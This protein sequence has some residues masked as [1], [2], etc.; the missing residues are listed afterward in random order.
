M[1]HSALRRWLN[2]GD[3][4]LGPWQMGR[5]PLERALYSFEGVAGGPHIH[6]W[7][8]GNRA[9]IGYAM[10]EQREEE[11]GGEASGSTGEA[12]CDAAQLESACCLGE[13][14][15]SMQLWMHNNK[16]RRIFASG[17]LWKRSSGTS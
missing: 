3:A 14:A 9:G 6:P 2:P 1:L 17:V 16:R 15:P 4:L 8:A 7:Q 10:A 12:G 13:A 11:D 5:D